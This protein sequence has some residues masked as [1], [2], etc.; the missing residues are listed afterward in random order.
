[1]IYGGVMIWEG[2]CNRICAFVS[3]ELADTFVFV[4]LDDS[5]NYQQSEIEW[6]H[7]SV[8]VV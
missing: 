4:S 3:Q 1:V 6:N 2:F 8:V 5:V 7:P